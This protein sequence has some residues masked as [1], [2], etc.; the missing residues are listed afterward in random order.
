MFRVESAPPTVPRV[1]VAPRRGTY[2][3]Q[4]LSC[5]IPAANDA[6]VTVTSFSSVEDDGLGKE[7]R[8]G[9]LDAKWASPIAKAR[10]GMIRLD[11]VR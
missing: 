1:V 7:L 6:A 11:P 8:V 4:P 10:R 5:H 3:L 9:A 2:C